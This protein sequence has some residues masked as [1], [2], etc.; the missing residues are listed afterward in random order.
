MSAFPDGH[1]KSCWWVCKG[2]IPPKQALRYFLPRGSLSMRPNNRNLMGGG[3]YPILWHRPRYCKLLWPRTSC[4]CLC[5][6]LSG[7]LFRILAP[8]LWCLTPAVTHKKCHKSST[9]L[10]ALIFRLISLLAVKLWKVRIIL[11]LV[12][13]FAWFWCISCLTKLFYLGHSFWALHAYCN[14]AFE[15]LVHAGGFPCRHSSVFWAHLLARL[16]I[17]TKSHLEWL[18]IF[19]FYEPVNN[20]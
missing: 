2:I 3:Y 10:V 20:D 5:L 9:S 7:T 19:H 1:N 13:N 17:L 11:P 15:A 8:S 14:N 6:A 4:C 12:C 18:V 16:L